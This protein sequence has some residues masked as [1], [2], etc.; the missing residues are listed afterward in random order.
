MVTDDVDLG[1]EAAPV[2]QN[3]TFGGCVEVGTGIS[4]NVGADGSLFDLF[5]DSIA[6]ELFTQ[7]FTL[8]QV[9]SGTSTGGASHDI[10]V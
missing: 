10:D 5:E 3:N 4:V 7:N 2:P 6:K 8:F 9:S 1:S